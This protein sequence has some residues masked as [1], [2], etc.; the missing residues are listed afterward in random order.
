MKSNLN[1]EID[2]LHKNVISIEFKRG[3]KSDSQSNINSAPNTELT[4]TE[5]QK[6]KALRRVHDIGNLVSWRDNEFALPQLKN[7]P[8]L[9]K[10]LEGITEQD[11]R[12]CRA[13]YNQVNRE[14]ALKKWLPLTP[15]ERY[16]KYKRDNLAHG[17]GLL[18]EY[19]KA[20]SNRFYDSNII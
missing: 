6:E 5:E 2:S 3:I 11:L 8:H 19:A 17:H 9:Y 10:Q 7:I 14:C 1:K 4:L 13:Y 16:Q 12:Y 15:A 18:D 20:C